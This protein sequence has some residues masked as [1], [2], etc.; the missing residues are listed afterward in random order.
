MLIEK[1]PGINPELIPLEGRTPL[2]YAIYTQ[3]RHEVGVVG[4]TVGHKE[5]KRCLIVSVELF[6]R[7]VAVELDSEA[8]GGGRE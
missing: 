4:V 6:Q 3:C 5:K 8:V 2:W 7:P 1:T